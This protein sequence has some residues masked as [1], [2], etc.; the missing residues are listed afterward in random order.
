MGDQIQGDKIGV[1]ELLTMVSRQYEVFHIMIEEGNYMRRNTDKVVK[2]WTE[3]LGQRAIWLSDCTKISEVIVSTIQINEGAD[4]TTVIN[5][6]DGSTAVA[7][8]RAV[9]GLVKGVDNREVVRF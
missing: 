3:L 2:D 7:V 4:L 1:Q 5:S 6:W 8:N 9:G